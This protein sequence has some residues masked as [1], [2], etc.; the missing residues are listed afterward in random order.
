MLLFG[1]LFLLGTMILVIKI[2][3]RQV[4]ALI[5]N[6][7]AHQAPLRDAVKTKTAR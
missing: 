7:H 1:V 5:T 6:L 3:D 4:R 2:Q